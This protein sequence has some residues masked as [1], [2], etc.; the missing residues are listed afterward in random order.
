MSSAKNFFRWAASVALSL[1]LLFLPALPAAKAKAKGQDPVTGAF[2]GQVT[3][4]NTGR[5]ITRARV[6]ITNVDTGAKYVRVTNAS[7]N[8]YQGALSPGSY[9]VV[10]EAPGYFR[11]ELTQRLFATQVNT[12]VPV[13]VVL[14]PQPVSLPVTPVT[15]A[16]T[17][18]D[19]TRTTP[20]PPTTTPPPTATTSTTPSPTATAP[21]AGTTATATTTTTTGGA[22]DDG[23][24]VNVE[25]VNRTDGRRSGAF[26]DREVSTLPLGATTLVRTFDELALLLPGV[27]LPPYTFGNVAGPGVGAGVGS[28]GQF[29]SNGMPPRANNFTVDGS[30]NNDED[31]GVRRQGFLSL[32]PQ[33]IE[34]IKEYQVITL[35]APAQF[36]RNIG[37]Q[38]NA[39]SR[40]G[41][42]EFHGEVYG[43]FNSSQLN[44]RN[45]FD[46]TSDNSFSALVAGSNQPVVVERFTTPNTGAFNFT[47]S[48]AQS[49]LQ[50]RNPA[51]GE[52]SF[53]LGQGGFVLG[54]PIKPRTLF[55]FVSAER[56]VLN[57][58]QEKS[59]AVPTVEERGFNNSGATG[60]ARDPFALQLNG[61]PVP[62]GQAV[63]LVPQSLT[64]AAFLSLFPFPNNP[65]GVYGANTFTQILPASGRGTVASGKIDY[66]NPSG[67]LL[68]S[69]TAR[70]NFTD[71][72]RDIPAAGG[73]IFAAL[74]PEVRTQNFSTF[75]NS[76]LTE[77]GASDPF[78]N[79]LRLSYGR[80]RLDFAELRDTSF[81]L[82]SQSFLL[83][84]PVLQ[85]VTLPQ[86]AG[87]A[88]TG[89]VRFAQLTF[90][91]GA[92][93]TTQDI[94][95][96]VGQVVIGGFSPVGVDVFNFPQQRVNN[97]YQ[98]ADTAT[99]SM[100]GEMPITLTF[101]ADIRRTELNSDLPRN[102]R[103]LATFFGAPALQNNPALG[104][105]TAIDPARGIPFIEPTLFAAAGIPS[106]FFQSL[107][108]PGNESGNIG[109]RYYQYNFFGQESIRLRPNL[110]LML[111]V[112]Y[113]YN[114]PARE[115][116]DRIENTFALDPSLS[117]GISLFTSGRTNIFDPDRD[118]IAPRLGVAWSPNVFGP[119]RPTVFRGGFGVYYDQILGAV[120]S[121]SRSVFPNF[122]PL[123]VGS[124]ASVLG[125]ANT[126]GV[127]LGFV[128]PQDLRLG[129]V[130]PGTGILGSC[131]FP[132]GANCQLDP[133]TGS[134]FL[135]SGGLNT[136]NRVFT[137]S[138]PQL[139]GGLINALRRDLPDAFNFTLPERNLEMPMAYHYSYSIEQAISRHTVLSLAY[140][141]TTGRNLLRFT[142]PNNGP[143]VFPI[144]GGVCNPLQTVCPSVNPT[145][146]A[147]G[148]TIVGSINRP[149]LRPLSPQ[150][151]PVSIFETTGRSQYDALQVQLRGTFARRLRYQTSY[152]FSRAFDSVS[153]VFDL[154]GSPALPQNSLTLR[155]EFARSNF[156][157]PHR[158]A[159]NF[160]WDIVPGANGFQLAST[161][162]F[163]SGQP[164]TVNSIIDIN[165]DGNLTDRLNTLD[166]VNVTDD[167]R[168]RLTLSAAN[169]R[170]L[171][172]PL[173]LDGAVRRN[174]F[175]A[176]NFALVNLTLVKKFA[177]T[178]TQHLSLRA[179][180]FNLLDRENFG[181]PV[182]FLEAPGFGGATETV[183]PGRR[184]QLGIKYTF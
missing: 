138:N 170:N 107:A 157:V 94:L 184:L 85:N 136:L 154:A 123:N 35:L 13:P 33:P 137:P 174:S 34:S 90:A 163:Q 9:R 177:F 146:L 84:A 116:N 130:T 173:G 68:Q 43:L 114:T 156:D 124:V 4:V 51:G 128:R 126:L 53:T 41:T 150:L 166:G 132:L 50:V 161:G 57:A 82:P 58:T 19:T 99:Y 115:V 178:E 22:D 93:V 29:S 49:A 76:E 31:I 110:S 104:G 103:P 92:P 160:I 17:P 62:G 153:D 81:L 96:P 78:F 97:T 3:D 179:D 121:Q 59:F 74:R 70:Y 87:V 66:V 142:T 102:A 77:P 158:L 38:V 20:P 79:Q 95:G 91:N 30:D 105:I 117:T 10:V 54:G 88:N 106:G 119:D 69:L 162:Q 168:Q 147:A 44:S 129:T 118:N 145:G 1:A 139:L 61:Q 55:F 134:P 135:I 176:G 37:A 155:G 36:G 181:I 63:R 56:Q 133:A 47:A 18:A 113:E 182:R 109:L 32:V 25:E 16:A 86:A 42:N 98:I 48:G 108:A 2:S 60:L 89:A 127:N 45:F 7:G 101:G 39:I 72:E 167:S 148:P 172:A 151:G 131:I 52:D 144:I 175:R 152:T 120:V 183:T 14:T 75:F 27:T 26:T 180:L 6:E 149:P 67:R 141:G 159:Y 5:P 40:S 111:G 23:E 140:V 46:T 165:T 171:L 73:A 21:P 64:G 71:D 8:F 125:S 83:N 122:V 65:G 15:P 100:S 143:N 24:D 169:T 80:T 164:F 28:A 112:R 11:A 12:V